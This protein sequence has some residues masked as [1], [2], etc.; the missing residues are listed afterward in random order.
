MRILSVCLGA[1]SNRRRFSESGELIER[2]FSQWERVRV[3]AKGQ[4]LGEDLEVREGRDDSVRL[5]AGSDID[6]LVQSSRRPEIRLAVTVPSSTRAPIAAGWTLGRFQVMLGD[7]VA[8]E[9]PAVAR[10]KVSR[11]GVFNGLQDLLNP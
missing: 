9:G 11:A 3:V 5:V 2:A 1:R 8:A 4:D 6:L 7:S 10:Q